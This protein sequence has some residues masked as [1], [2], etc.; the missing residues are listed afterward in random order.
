[1]PV[2]RNYASYHPVNTPLSDSSNHFNYAS[3]L[4]QTSNLAHVNNYHSNLAH[5]NDYHT[6]LD[7]QAADILHRSV[8]TSTARRQNMQLNKFLAWCDEKNVAEQDRSPPSEILLCNY[9]STFA[10]KTSMATAKAHRAAIKKWVERRGLHW[11]GA[12]LLDGIMKGINNTIPPSSKRPAR[13]P[14]R[15]DH[16]RALMDVTAINPSLN[17]IACRDAAASTAFYGLLRLGE[18]LPDK[19]EDLPSLP[20]VRDLSIPSFDLQ[21]TLFL[22]KTKTAQ[23][24]GEKVVIPKIQSRTDPIYLLLHHIEVNNL[25]PDDP[26]F[27]YSGLPLSLPITDIQDMNSILGHKA[28]LHERPKVKVSTEVDTDFSDRML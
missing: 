5:V 15:A 27:A 19:D 21:G 10:T 25:L 12:A 28:Q 14:V 20:R 22:P 23:I 4:V 6:S 2:F 1:M 7:N 18:I 17:F 8:S 24:S 3:Q 16:L 13:S 26:L 9:F 11:T